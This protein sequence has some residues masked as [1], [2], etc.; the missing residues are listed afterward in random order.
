M[1]LNNNCSS[2]P[3]SLRILLFRMRQSESKRCRPH[4]HF[5]SFKFVCRVEIY[6]FRTPWS[7]L[8]P[9]A[10]TPQPTLIKRSKCLVPLRKTRKIHHPISPINQPHPPF[11]NWTIP[12]NNHCC[13][14]C[15]L[16]ATNAKEPPLFFAQH[17]GTLGG[18]PKS[19][20]TYTQPRPDMPCLSQK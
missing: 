9:E 11:G 17:L 2:S 6:V 19:A 1:I 18:V 4:S 14:E 8:A 13:P 20:E 3:T 12:S 10:P 16:S 5:W 7:E 15:L